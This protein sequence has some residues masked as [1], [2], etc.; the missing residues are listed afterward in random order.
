MGMFL[1]NVDV[2]L[3]VHTAL[4][5]EK[6]HGHFCILRAPLVVVGHGFFTRSEEIE[7]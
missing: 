5:S 4:K 6:E 3:L 2:Y 1:R 7:N